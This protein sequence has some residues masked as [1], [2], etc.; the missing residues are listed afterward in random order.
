MPSLLS[1]DSAREGG[2]DLSLS[3]RRKSSQSP[4][5]ARE[6]GVDLSHRPDHIPCQRILTPPARAGWI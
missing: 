3:A 6:G 5:S 1:K 4:D 2:V